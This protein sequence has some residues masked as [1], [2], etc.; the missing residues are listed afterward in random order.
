MPNAQWR[1]QWAYAHK[2]H[3]HTHTHTPI[4]AVLRGPPARR[5]RRRAPL[6][7]AQP[8]RLDGDDQPRG[9]HADRGEAQSRPNLPT[10]SWCFPLSISHASVPTLPTPLSAP[11]TL[12]HP[13]RARPTSSSAVSE[14]T[15]ARAAW[16]AAPAAGLTSTTSRSRPRRTSERRG[17]RRP[18]SQTF[19]YARRLVVCK[20]VC[21]CVRV[22]LFFEACRGE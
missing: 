6:L 9:A 14:S 7:R 17:I 22:R 12:P 21:V 10:G 1:T 18:P 8:V 11:H 13:H 15:S 3:T 4:A 19:R 2:T 20:C 16:R 5:A